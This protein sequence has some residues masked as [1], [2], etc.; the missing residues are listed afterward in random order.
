MATDQGT[1]DLSDARYERSVESRRASDR[2]GGRWQVLAGRD[3]QGKLDLEL[4]ARADEAGRLTAWVAFRNRSG[5]AMKISGIYVLRGTRPGA[6]AGGS[7]LQYGD[8]PM[9][10]EKGVT[11]G[12]TWATAVN[13]PAFVG[14]FLTNDHYTGSVTVTP[15]EGG[16]AV[17]AYN[18]G[19]G[20]T[21][22][23]GAERASDVLWLSP[24]VQVMREM[25]LFGQ[26]TGAWYGVRPWPR[27]FAT[28][29]SWYTGLTFEA[30]LKGQLEAVTLAN[31]PLIRDKF[32]PYGL[33]CARVVDDS[34]K[35][36]AGD[37]PLA[38]EALP[39]GYA[40]MAQAMKAHGLR[41]GF[42]Y[43]SQRVHTNSRLFAE[44]PEWLMR[45]GA[46]PWSIDPK[47]LVANIYG[48]YG[49][50][51]ASVPAVARYFRDVAARFRA[52]GQRYC[53]TD[54]IGES[55][56]TPSASHDPLLT[57]AEVSR[58]AIENLR[59]GFGRDF[60]YLSQNT[61]VANRGLVDAMRTGGD[62]FGD[63]PHTY[64][65]A[66]YGWFLNRGPF[67]CDPDAWCPLRHSFEWDRAWGSWQALTGNPITIGADLRQ[68]TPKHEAMIKRLLPPLNQTG[69]P[70][71]IFERTSPV[72]LAQSFAQGGEAWRVLALSKW[73]QYLS[74]VAL[75]LDRVWDDARYRPGFAAA[76]GSL[77]QTARRYLV[78]DFWEEKFLGE[79]DGLCRLTLAREPGTRVLAVREAQ[80]HPQILAVGDHIGQGVEE[81]VS[82]AWDAKRK[83]LTAVTRGRR[84]QVDTVVRLRVPK[85]WTVREVR[86]G[87][88]ALAFDQPEAEV[89]RFTVPDREGKVKWRVRFE[90]T[91]AAP[92]PAL[93]PVE[94]G[95]AALVTLD[96]SVKDEVR[97]TLPQTSK[98][99]APAER[100]AQAIPA[101]YEL[102]LYARNNTTNGA[103]YRA[104][105]GLGML[106]GGAFACWDALLY[107]L[108]HE[109]W[110]D[111]TK[112]AYRF[113]LLEAGRRYK[114]GWTLYD[115]DSDKRRATLVA[116]RA[117]DGKEFV[118]AENL[119]EPSMVKQ[120]KPALVWR[121]LPAEAVD[122]KGV[123]FEVRNA[124]GG[125]NVNAAELWL[126]VQK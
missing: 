92:A 14:A 28:W 125:G 78:Y 39:Q 19:E 22:P 42:W 106:R 107:G 34:K 110:F 77:G 47:G 67:L 4:L 54:F 5:Q 83:T 53:F 100:L 101:G 15:K 84:G 102:V 108:T 31:L 57:G 124:A 122:P 32:L 46:K 18:A 114:V 75:N 13:Q 6:W 10:L 24:G 8:G 116:V 126:A 50:L 40:A 49:V 72:L 71:D 86:A 69:R 93:R 65:Q 99:L 20:V 27:N 80:N 91:S 104:G 56:V 37:W 33:E 55:A 118:L 87:R 44:R 117:A 60:Y 88:R 63:N 38:T 123:I 48:V 113:D 30:N 7:I 73:D 23:A 62:S 36:I 35:R 12:A 112:I 96:P 76:P 95:L 59:A 109:C 17:E 89:C 51:D 111:H 25:E 70:L 94:P 97:R 2:L 115:H 121:E 103:P 1:F 26:L 66:L 61:P 119:V 85:G 90:G 105:V 29:C 9:P 16:L 98:N 74:H 43:D 21:L 45:D 82:S 81:L 52:S 58:R 79:M 41:P 11:T 120:E 3:R 68:L 64:N